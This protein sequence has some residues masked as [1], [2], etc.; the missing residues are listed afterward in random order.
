M[1]GETTFERFAKQIAVLMVA[2]LVLLPVYWMI[3]MS[4]KGRGEFVCAA[5]NHWL[6]SSPTTE[7]YY[8]LLVTQR[9]YLKGIN[10][11]VVA[12][13]RGHASRSSSGLS[14][15]TPSPAST[16]RETSITNS[17]SPC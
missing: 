9:F 4:F 2:L 5:A 13:D 8:D 11:L 1:V 16:C 3:N 7:N 6:S 12:I 14:R 17:F 15:P 10:S